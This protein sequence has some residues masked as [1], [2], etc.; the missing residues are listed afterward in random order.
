MSQWRECRA[1][2]RCTPV[3]LAEDKL[4]PRRG[5]VIAA[6]LIQ[7]GES[8]HQ[9]LGECAGY[10]DTKDIGIGVYQ[11]GDTV[12]Y[13]VADSMPGP[14]KLAE[15]DFMVGDAI[16]HQGGACGAVVESGDEEYGIGLRDSC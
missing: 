10:L 2:C 5:P 7:E 12:H 6:V 16:G 11:P 8:V 15:G 3:G 1:E 4:W 14:W 9:Q 13:Q